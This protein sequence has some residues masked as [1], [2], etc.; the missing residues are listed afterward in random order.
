MEHVRQKLNEIKQKHLEMQEN[1]QAVQTS[2]PTND[3]S[4]YLVALGGVAAGLTLAVIAW[5]AKSLLA[6]GDI[7][8]PPP[9]S[10]VAIHASKIKET[11]ENID[12]LNKRVASLTESFSRMEARLKRVMEL[13]NPIG[14]TGMGHETSSQQNISENIGDETTDVS[15]DIHASGDTD[16]TAETEKSFVPTHI[17]KARINLRP[18]SSLDT[19]PI[20]VLEVGTKV[21]YIGKMD[22]WYY[23]NTQFQGKGWCSSEYLSPLSPPLNLPTTDD[24]DG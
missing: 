1:N 19:M 2:S 9:E 10:T 15:K 24:Q 12:Q 4:L 13:T 20:A 23:V 11:N 5:L 21:E 3:K 6:M 16:P 7:N 22:D 18:S 8:I 14:A 17:V